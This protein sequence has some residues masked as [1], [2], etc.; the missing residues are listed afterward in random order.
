MIALYAMWYNFVKLHKMIK[1]TPA[2]A[3]EVTD[4][5]WTIEDRAG[6][7]RLGSAAERDR[8]H[9]PE[10]TVTASASGG[11]RAASTLGVSTPDSRRRN[12][13]PHLFEQCG[14]R[15]A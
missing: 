1:M 15:S 9:G 4:T 5:L 3:A 6:H 12:V 13:R 8:R 2:I 11:S 14:W 10:G 7:R